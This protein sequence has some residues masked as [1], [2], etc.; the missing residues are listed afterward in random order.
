M[1]KILLIITLLLVLTGCASDIYIF[2][3]ENASNIS[4]WEVNNVTFFL[5]PINFNNNQTVRVFDLIIESPNS[6]VIGGVQNGTPFATISATEQFFPAVNTSVKT[7]QITRN[8]FAIDDINGTKFLSN[9]NSN[10]GANSSAIVSA[11]DPVGNGMIIQKYNGNNVEPYKGVLAS[12]NGNIDILTT[13]D[14]NGSSTGGNN[15]SIGFYKNLTVED[16]G[17]LLEYNERD[18][19]LIMNHTL[20]NILKPVD[21][22]EN[23]FFRH[24][25]STEIPEGKLGYVGMYCKDNNKCYIKR[26]N[27]VERRLVDSGAGSIVF[28]EELIIDNTTYF[29]SPTYFNSTVK[30][31]TSAMQGIGNAFA[32]LDSSGNL[33]RSSTACI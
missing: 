28:D 23:L 17:I 29:N 33:Y 20:L 4:L 13:F 25:N 7:V 10:F 2:E 27:G 8:V 21:I 3:D 30:F 15:I 9:L 31:E 19:V 6:L 5:E 18:F 12:L 22:E 24:L 32:C 1:N 16:P 11:S 26:S 14:N